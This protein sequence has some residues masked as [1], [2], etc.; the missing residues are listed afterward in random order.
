MTHLAQVEALRGEIDEVTREL[1]AL[2]ERRAELSQRVGALKSNADLPARDFMREERLLRQAVAQARG[3]LPARSIE[4]IV[5]QIID[6]GMAT[7]GVGSDRAPLLGRRVRGTSF[8]DS[9]VQDLG[10]GLGGSA[11]I[12]GPCA[13]ESEAQIDEAAS[14]LSR[15]GV[16]WLRGGGFKPRTSP[17]AFAGLG[18]SGVRALSAAAKRHGMR[19]VTEVLDPRDVADV[20]EHVDALQIG[21]RNMQC[22]PLLREVA[23]AGLPVILKRGFGATLAEWLAA[24]EHIAAAGD[25]KIVLCERGIRTFEDSTRAT[26]DLASVPQAQAA[27][28]LPVIVDVSHAAGRRALVA[29]LTRAAFA[30]GADAVMIEVHP[31]PDA[32]RSDAAQQLDLDDFERLLRSLTDTFSKLARDF[33]ARSEMADDHLVHDPAP[34]VSWASASLRSRT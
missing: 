12:A 6:E 13:V 20:A 30:V 16:G 24:A 22:F 19:C 18:L 27:T 7:R 9:R 29:P 10:L 34:R 25:A 14:R 11:F 15:L 4:A 28:G 8:Q 3:V 33:D 23:Q 26:L 17:H 5:Q 21:A 32:A 2:V 31:D 1:V